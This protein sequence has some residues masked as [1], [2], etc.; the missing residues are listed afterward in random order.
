MTAAPAYVD[1]PGCAALLFRRSYADLGLPGALM[2]RAREW[3][4]PMAARWNAHDHVW[5]FPS[6]ATMTF[7]YVE[8]ENDRFRCQP[9]EFQ[10][11]AFDDLTQSTESQYCSLA[12]GEHQ[13]RDQRHRLLLHR[14]GIACE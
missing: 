1:V 8:T 13:P 2:G 5:T 4:T 12:S 11:I 6:E 3:L 7:G 9:A 10:F 14:P